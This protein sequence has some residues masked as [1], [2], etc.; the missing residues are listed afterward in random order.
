V[1]EPERQTQKPFLDERA[2]LTTA[3]RGRAQAAGDEA[4][5]AFRAQA[6]R[7]A[8]E[9]DLIRREEFEALKAEVEAEITRLEGEFA[10][11]V[12]RLTSQGSTLQESMKAGVGTKAKRNLVVGLEDQEDVV[13]PK[14]EVISDDMAGAVLRKVQEKIEALEANIRSA[15]DQARGRLASSQGNLEA[16]IEEA[17][18]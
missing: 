7:V 1:P 12:D 3:A 16:E 13:V 18:R 4:K 6:D 17:T 14:G 11:G 2:K 8:A 10:A 9:F 5:A 15:Q